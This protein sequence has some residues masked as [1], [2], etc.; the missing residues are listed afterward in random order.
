MTDAESFSPGDIYVVGRLMSSFRDGYSEFIKRVE[1]SME[2]L[3][4][5]D[6]DEYIEKSGRTLLEIRK[7][8]E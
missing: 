4:S 8:E 6:V 7:K 1:D 2:S 5:L 3:A